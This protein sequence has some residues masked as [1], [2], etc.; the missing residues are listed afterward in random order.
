MFAF[1]RPPL[2]HWARQPHGHRSFAQR[3]GAW[4]AAA[5]AAGGGAA[6]AGSTGASRT[7][8]ATTTAAYLMRLIDIGSR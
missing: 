2:S 6:A 7:R 8:K 4:A 5:P 3:C 1:Q